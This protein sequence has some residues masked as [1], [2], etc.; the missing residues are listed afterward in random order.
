MC[1]RLCVS[2]TKAL[3][4]FLA[5]CLEQKKESVSQTWKIPLTEAGAEATVRVTDVRLKHAQ[6]AHLQ[7]ILK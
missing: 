4:C 6:A 3:G 1:S 7:P 2:V 5:S